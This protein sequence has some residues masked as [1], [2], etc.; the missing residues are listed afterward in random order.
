MIV[1]EQEEEK[2]RHDLVSK[3]L[4]GLYSES[5]I[6][7]CRMLK[8]GVSNRSTCGDAVEESVYHAHVCHTTVLCYT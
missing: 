8:K 7:V 4:G 5:T 1:I 2:A 3:R 6:E